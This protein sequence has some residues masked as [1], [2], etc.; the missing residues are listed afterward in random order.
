MKM[1]H[2]RHVKQLSN[3]NQCLIYGTCLVTGKMYETKPFPV[4]VY[5]VYHRGAEVKEALK[6]L[7]EDDIEFVLSEI[8]PEGWE[9]VRKDFEQDS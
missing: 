1:I 4:S 8:S 3:N 7:S 5:E 6:C 2:N 9:I